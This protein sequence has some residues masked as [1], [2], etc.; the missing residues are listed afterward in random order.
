MGQIG[1]ASIG[2]PGELRDEMVKQLDGMGKQTAMIGL[3]SHICGLN[4][5]TQ[6]P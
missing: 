1:I 2:V 5:T 3:C 6:L 4:V